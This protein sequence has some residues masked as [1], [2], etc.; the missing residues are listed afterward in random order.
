MNIE[1][2]YFDFNKWYIRPDAEVELDK[3]VQIMKE[4]PVKIELGKHTDSRGSDEYNLDLSQKRAESV[5]RYIVQQGIESERISA[6]GY[7]ELSPVNGC[8][9]GVPCSPFQHQANRR[10]EFKITGFN[11]INTTTDFDLN[12]FIA[13]DEIPVYMFDKDFYI[14]CLLS[15]QTANAGKVPAKVTSPAE[16]AKT[17]AKTSQPSEPVK[18]AAKVTQPTQ[19]PI[20][21]RNTA[22]ASEAAKTPEKTTKPAN[23]VKADP[24]VTIENPKDKQSEKNKL[25]ETHATTYRVQ[26]FALSRF[27]PS[28]SQEFVNLNNFQNYQEDG[29]Y[30]YTSG[31]FATYEEAHAYRDIMVNAG[32]P[33]SFVVKFENGKHVNM[34][35]ANK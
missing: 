16:T 35:Q 4:N 19:Q 9:N 29:L 31:K 23:T 8:Y 11:T 3:L 27:I 5:V 15:N 24:V 10:A 26:L 1:N 17:P 20:S 13:G 32:F 6:K 33:D 25:P 28:N 22:P 7:G 18:V 12:K 34:A 21:N 14:N 2:I 30:K